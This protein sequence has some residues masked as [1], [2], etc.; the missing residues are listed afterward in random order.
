MQPYSPEAPLGGAA[1]APPAQLASDPLVAL[2]RW[3]AAQNYRFVTVTPETH[4]RVLQR[5]GGAIGTSLRDIFGWSCPFAR[6]ALPA[7]VFAWL[8][9][10]DALAPCGAGYRSR[11]RCSTIDDR[12]YLHSAYPTLGEDAVFFGPDTYRFCRF[13]RQELRDVPAA[14][15]RLIVDVGCGSGA[16]GLTARQALA[17]AGL[18]FAPRLLLTDIN[19][20]A[21]R[22][23]AVNAALA[24]EPAVDCRYSDVLGAVDEAPDL[25]IANP[26]Y[27]IDAA[28]RTY[29]NG[30]GE[31][32]CALS[33][34]IVAEALQRLAAGGRLLL[35]S[36]APIADG[37]DLLWQAL[38]PLLRAA[39]AEYRY[40]E[41]D[42]DVFGE[43]LEHA[44]YAF[45]ER[46]A[47]VGLSLRMPPAPKGTP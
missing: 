14:D 13:L 34:R 28:A 38:Q 2:G 3:L 23:A 11:L 43:E 12:L 40:E 8:D 19:D 32:G 1:P 42:P 36:G 24:D 17:P 45:V 10:A 15:L 6:E 47:A 44:H 22:L 35:Y 39:G 21:L 9:A 16:G 18:A 31:H 7:A 25:V 29:R 46:I 30:G 37:Q 41:L 20:Q 33:Q 27:L 4:R 26:P 5:S